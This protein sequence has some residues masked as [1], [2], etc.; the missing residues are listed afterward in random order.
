[1]VVL[2]GGNG[3]RLGLDK[4]CLCRDGR[5]LLPDLVEALRRQFPEVLVAVGRR[6]PFP[7]ALGVGDVEDFFPG[8]GPLSGLHAGLAVA[9]YPLV[10]AVACDMP[11]PVP[12]LLALVG[13]AAGPAQAAVCRIRGY[14]EPF[15][16]AYPRAFLPQVERAL[17]DGLGV[18]AFLARVPHAVVPEE[19]AR[20][21]DPELRSFVNL[22]T[23]DDLRRW[24]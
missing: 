1:M 12:G 13:Q 21:V 10:L 19:A 18:Q 23:P 17:R 9:S 4:A 3:Q 7:F 16:G 8:R 6:R 22:N 15:P 20:R 24:L 11:F 14:V 2:A 5:P